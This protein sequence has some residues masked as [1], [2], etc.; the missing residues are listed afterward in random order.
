MSITALRKLVESSKA[1]VLVG[2]V[3]VMAVLVYLGKLDA[4]QM[5]DTIKILVPGWMLAHAGERGAKHIA[6]GKA[7]DS[8]YR[9]K[10]PPPAPVSTFVGT[11]AADVKAGEVV[12]VAFDVPKPED[13][14]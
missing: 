3:A 8:V 10:V 12:A 2:V 7:L 4:Q 11:A 13:N 5:L 6:N 9:G 1:T 14:A